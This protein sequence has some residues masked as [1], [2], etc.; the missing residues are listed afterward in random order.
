MAL[1]PIFIKFLQQNDT[2]LLN[3]GTTTKMALMNMTNLKSLG[4]QLMGRK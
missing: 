1:K 2:V 3:M 4:V